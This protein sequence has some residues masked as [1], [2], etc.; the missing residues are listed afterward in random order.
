M[1]INLS[2]STFIRIDNVTSNSVI[3]VP[4]NC[5]VRDLFALLKLPSYLQKSIIARVNNEPTWV[6]TVLKENDSV[7]ILRALSGG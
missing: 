4:E 5:T 7:T 6:A 3:E 2:Y 1:K